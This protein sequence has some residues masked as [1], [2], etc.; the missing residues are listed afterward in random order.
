MIPIYNETS[1]TNFHSST[2]IW[3]QAIVSKYRSHAAGGEANLI[4]SIP[5]SIVGRQSHGNTPGDLT[6]AWELD[7]GED[8]VSVFR[9]SKL[10]PLSDYHD[11]NLF[12]YPQDWEVNVC[13]D[14]RERRIWQEYR[15]L[16]PES[17][18][19][20]LDDLPATQ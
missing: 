5:L 10:P 8:V 7:V 2:V 17:N 4:S 13:R 6:L 15:H 18:S 16:Q 14:A 19:M 12:L 9:A 3:T 20:R 11:R 1:Y